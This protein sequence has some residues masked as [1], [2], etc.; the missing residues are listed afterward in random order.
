MPGEGKPEAGL[1]QEAVRERDDRQPKLR[2]VWEEVQIWGGVLQGT[3]CE[4]DEMSTNMASKPYHKKA[5]GRRG[6]LASATGRVKSGPRPGSLAC[7]A[8]RPESGQ[9]GAK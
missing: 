5:A 4:P 1:L 8:S 2:A 6:N 3:V 9:L 7:L